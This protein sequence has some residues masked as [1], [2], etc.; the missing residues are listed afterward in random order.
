MITRKIITVPGILLV[1]IMLFTLLVPS[2]AA[3]QGNGKNQLDVYTATITHAQAA[4]LSREGYDIAAKRGAPGGVEVD[5]V[6]SNA[7][8][9]RGPA[10]WIE[11]E[12][13]W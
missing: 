10:T 13:G 2:A 4:K 3:L 6:L 8:A 11:E 7:E 1:L 12:S 5:L 9:A